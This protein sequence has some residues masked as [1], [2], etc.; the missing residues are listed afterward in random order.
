MTETVEVALSDTE[1]RQRCEELAKA[2]LALA[3]QKKEMDNEA[4]EWKDRKK[5]LQSRIE[6][7][8]DRV[9]VLAREVDTRKA[10]VDAQQTLPGTA[11]EMPGPEP[12]AA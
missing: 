12:D 11:P 7:T 3:E 2:E 9:S 5:E 10:R 6:A 4:E 1:W 8:E